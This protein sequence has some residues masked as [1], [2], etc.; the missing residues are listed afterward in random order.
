[1]LVRQRQL[2]LPEAIEVLFLAVVK[3]VACP[4]GFEIP[5]SDE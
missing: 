4:Y 3:L 2:D 1:M 5:A